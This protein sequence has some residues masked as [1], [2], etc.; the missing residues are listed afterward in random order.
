MSDENVACGC[1]NEDEVKSTDLSEEA[2]GDNNLPV[3]DA[4]FLKEKVNLDQLLTH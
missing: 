1:P 3:Y 2:G 4:I